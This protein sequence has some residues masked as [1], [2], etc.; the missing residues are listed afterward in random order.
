MNTKATNAKL[1][2]KY[3]YDCIANEYTSQG[4]SN[5]LADLYQLAGLELKN[6]KELSRDE[7]LAIV[8]PHI[9]QHMHD[10]IEAVEAVRE[11]L[12]SF[13]TLKNCGAAIFLV[14]ISIL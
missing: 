11:D 6:E 5:S 12:K 2:S 14:F 3:A 13:S 7:H 8:M 4:T 1:L 9:P 10:K